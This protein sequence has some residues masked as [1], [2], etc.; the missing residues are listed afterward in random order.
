MIG[1]IY[2]IV[3]KNE[4]IIDRYIGSSIQFNKRKSQ[5]IHDMPL[6]PHLPLYMCISENGGIDNWNFNI[7]E[8]YECTTRQELYQRERLYYEIYEPTLNLIK[9]YISDKLVCKALCDAKYPEKRRK[10]RVIRYHKDPE[11]FKAAAHEYYHQNK[12]KKLAYD[13]SRRDRHNE[14]RRESTARKR[15]E[16]NLMGMEDHDAGK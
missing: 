5:Y 8:E 11:K 2:E 14:L 10:E 9:P 7:L 12:E 13:K 16:L 15:N 1:V 6:K 4:E 3:C